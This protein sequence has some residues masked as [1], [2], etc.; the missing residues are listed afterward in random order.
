MIPQGLNLSTLT[1]CNGHLYCTHYHSNNVYP[2]KFADQNPKPYHISMS[3]QKKSPQ[4]FEGDM[5]MSVVI[6][7]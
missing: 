1:H 3:L 7:L 5:R 2:H 6:T 4:H